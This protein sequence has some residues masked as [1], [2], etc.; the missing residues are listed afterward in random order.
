MQSHGSYML[1]GGMLGYIGDPEF[2]PDDILDEGESYPVKRLSQK[3]Y[4][5]VNKAYR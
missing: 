3:R 5:N 2:D 1:E 4:S